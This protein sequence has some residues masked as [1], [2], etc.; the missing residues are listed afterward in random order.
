MILL[1]FR[2]C[3]E[4]QGPIVESL[5]VISQNLLHGHNA[6][7]T[8]P[9]PCPSSC[10]LTPGVD[11]LRRVWNIT[12]HCHICSPCFMLHLPGMFQAAFVVLF[13]W[14]NPPF[15]QKRFQ[16]LPCLQEQHKHKCIAHG[17]DTPRGG[18][19]RGNVCRRDASKGGIHGAD[20]DRA[21]AHRH[22]TYR[23]DAHRGSQALAPDI[24][25]HWDS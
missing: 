11:A 22:D 3:C 15:T 17:V 9:P 21:D 18:V 19:S 14:K 16:V 5:N 12:S 7:L 6:A 10:S 1:V 20:A 13:A 24:W 25:S 8:S 4:S 2:S 23:S